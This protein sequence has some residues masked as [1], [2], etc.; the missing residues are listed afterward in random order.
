ML[1]QLP[2]RAGAEHM[3]KIDD[4]FKEPET[5]ECVKRVN[6]ISEDNWKKYTDDSFVPLQG[7]LLKYPLKIFMG[8]G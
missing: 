4:I 7:H 2:I 6:M 5:L 1:L 3:G 8:F